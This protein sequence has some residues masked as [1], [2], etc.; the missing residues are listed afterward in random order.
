VETA[1]RGTSIAARTFNKELETL[2]HVIRYARDVKGILLDNPAEK[3]RNRKAAITTIGIPSK[4]QFRGIVAELRN[5]PQAVRSGAAVFAEFLAYSGL[6]LGEGREV[7]WR[8][9]NFELNTLLVTGGETGTKS[10]E[11]RT[12]PLFSGAATFARSN[13]KRERRHRER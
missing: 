10:H 7:R 13:E 9:V 5:E 8:D 12:I 3:V 2:N 1:T 11:D 4:D 6:R